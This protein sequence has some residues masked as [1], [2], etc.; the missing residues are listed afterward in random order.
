MIPLSIGT[1]IIY[2]PIH[3]ENNESHPDC[4]TGF[5]TSQTRTD[6]AFCRYW[7][8]DGNDGLL[9][10]MS[11]SESTPLYLIIVRDTIPQHVV[12]KALNLLV[13]L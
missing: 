5:V 11:C 6:A 8:N 9:R 2:V 7:K 1:Q 13:T 3:A 10:T 12:D 4:E